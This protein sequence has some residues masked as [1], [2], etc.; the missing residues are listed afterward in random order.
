MAVHSSFSSKSYGGS[1]AK[2]KETEYFTYPQS[3]P[4]NFFGGELRSPRQEGDIQD[5]PLV[6]QTRN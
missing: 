6:F 5:R 2:E 4:E 3:S 1:Q